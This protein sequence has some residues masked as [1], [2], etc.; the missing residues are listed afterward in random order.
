MWE[1]ETTDMFDEWFHHQKQDLKEDVLAAL[2]ILSEYGPQLGRPWVDTVKASQYTN[3]K[4]LR[5][6]HA[7]DPIRAFFAFYPGRQAII[8]CAGNKTGAGDKRFYKRMINIADAEFS[9]YLASKEAKWQ[10]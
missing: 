4:E 7:G 10:R 2:H 6:Q 1:V 5:I 8:L 9:K 3:M